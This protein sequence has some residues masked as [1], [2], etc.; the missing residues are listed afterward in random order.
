M[1]VGV[2]YERGTPVE[3]GHARSYVGR[4]FCEEVVLRLK[5]VPISTAKR[6]RGGLVFEAHGLFVPLNFGLESDAKRRYVGISFAY[7]LCK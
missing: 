7:T 3:G 2:S 1:G 5:T 6:F 4:H